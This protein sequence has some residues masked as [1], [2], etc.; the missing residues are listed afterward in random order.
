MDISIIISLVS[1]VVAIVI[2]VFTLVYT[3]QQVD[4][5]KQDSEKRK[6]FLKTSNSILKVIDDI[7]KYPKQT[8]FDS[9]KTCS[10]LYFNRNA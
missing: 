2:P 5:L 7:K 4:I 10:S 1:I 9:L 8:S 6:N 3:K